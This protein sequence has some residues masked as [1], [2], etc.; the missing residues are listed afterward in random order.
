MSQLITFIES[1]RTESNS[2]VLDTIL[3]GISLIESVADDIRYGY[4]SGSLVVDPLTI[5]DDVYEKLYK[6]TK[7][8]GYD[9]RSGKDVKELL[10]KRA[11][12]AE[13]LGRSDG[14]TALNHDWAVAL[15]RIINVKMPT[16][17]PTIEQKQKEATKS[18]L[19]GEQMLKK[20]VNEFG[21]TTNPKL[22]GYIL[23]N[24]QLLSLGGQV[25]TRAHDHRAIVS[26][27]GGDYESLSGGMNDFMIRTGAI[28]W[29]SESPGFDLETKPNSSQLNMIRKLISLY[30]NK[31]FA[32]DCTDPVHGKDG[33]VYDKGT[34]PDKIIMDINRFYNGNGFSESFLHE[35]V[36]DKSEWKIPSIEGKNPI[37]TDIPPEK[38]TTKNLPRFATGKA[39]V[40]FQDW[41]CLDNLIGNSVGKSSNGKWYGWSHRA[42]YGFGIGDKVKK[43]DCAYNGK[44]YTIKTDAQAKQT[45][46]DFADSVS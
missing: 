34:R 14:M 30:P 41:L 8:L 2:L 36:S 37:K 5:P 9:T 1:L 6:A 28:R 32:L 24:G 38:R 20:V 21:Y 10:S 18:P 43:G 3:S 4:E 26:F 13:V 39:K 12:R 33:K 16:S 35:S 40:R 46:I 19:S 31:E 23:P 7:A 27:I 42:M 44:E 22:A 29:M 17:E 25:N 15:A 11:N 45:A